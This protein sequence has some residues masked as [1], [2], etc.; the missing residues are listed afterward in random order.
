MTKDAR[1]HFYAIHYFDY[2]QI[3]VMPKILCFELINTKDESSKSFFR[4]Y[5][6][7]QK[8]ESELHSDNLYLFL[9]GA[10]DKKQSKDVY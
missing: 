9:D 10:Y 6:T 1:V 7:S 4:I 2:T 8:A 5:E 3:H